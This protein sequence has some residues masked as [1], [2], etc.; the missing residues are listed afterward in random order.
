MKWTGDGHIYCGL[1]AS[2]DGV[3]FA[4]VRRGCSTLPLGAAGTWDAGRVALREAPFRAGDVWRQYYSGA[5][6]KHGLAGI[7]ARTSHVGLNGP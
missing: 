7:G 2:R 6:W 1:A 5:C 3:N 4:R